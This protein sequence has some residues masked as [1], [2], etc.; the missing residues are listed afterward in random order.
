MFC[1]LGRINLPI[2]NEYFNLTTDETIV[3]DER[4]SHIKQNH[5]QDVDLFKCY[6]KICI[7]HPDIVVQD[8]VNQGTVF[9][10]KKLPDTNLNVVVRLVLQGEDVNRKN[11][12]MTFYRIR[13][14]NL[15]KLINKNKLL[16][17]K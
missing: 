8:I 4:F 17:S 3:T 13:E 14:K 1:P 2:L 16:Y 7:E 12:V 11:S 10:I 6:G 5:P 15:E 9:M